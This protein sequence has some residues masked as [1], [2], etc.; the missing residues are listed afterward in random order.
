MS[1]LTAAPESTTPPGELP[2]LVGRLEQ[3]RDEQKRFRFWLG[4]A[5]FCLG[6]MAIVALGM[7]IDW[8]WVVPAWL[9]ALA[10]PALVGLAAFLFVRS[11]RPYSSPQ[12]AA[13][14]ERHF[15]EL[16]Q[17]VRT[18]LQY[19]DPQSSPVPASPGLLRA[20]VRQTDKQ[21]AITRLP[22]TGPVARL[23]AHGDRRCSSRRSSGS[24]HCSQALQLRTAALRM[25][26]LPA[27][28][29]TMKVEPGDGTLKAGETLKLAVTLDGRPVKTCAMDA[30]DQRRSVDL[31]SARCRSGPRSTRQ[32]ALGAAHG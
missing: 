20:L 19:A 18:V 16:G 10:L 14:A 30:S 29:T 7:F 3:A 28:Y 4:V 2:G 27:H 12:A 13:D 17:R 5:T 25:L 11:R 9:R 24:S 15:P 22:K 8:M 32:A 26:L 1:R 6:A 23:R 31:A 21:T